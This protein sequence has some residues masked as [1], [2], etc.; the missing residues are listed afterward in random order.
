[1]TEVIDLTGDA[2]D[3][4]IPVTEK[5]V[6]KANA[7][8]RRGRKWVLCTY[9]CNSHCKHL[10]FHRDRYIT[11]DR[12]SIRPVDY[13]HMSVW[14]QCRTCCDPTKLA[15]IHKEHKALTKL[16][17][18]IREAPTRHFDRSLC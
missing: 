13:H 3:I 17:A 11:V 9:H 6:V 14:V 7:W 8:E 15:H 10:Q 1:M 16:L 12:S 5:A 18:S 4:D 2:M